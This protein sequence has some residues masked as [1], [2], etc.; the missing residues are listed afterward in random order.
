MGQRR[1]IR[2]V[3]VAM[4]LVAV[5]CGS[6]ETND[7]EEATIEDATETSSV[8]GSA[9]ATTSTTA[10]ATS[11]TAADTSTTSGASTTTQASTTTEAPASSEA[12]GPAIDL[13]GDAVTVN[14]AALASTPS[15]A[16]ATDSADPFFQIHTSGQA[17]GFFLS[18]ELYTEW[19][20]RWSGQTGT[21]DISCSDPETSTGICPYFDPDGPG[22]DP[23]MG[24]DF[25]TQGSITINRLDDS[26]Y[27]IIVHELIFSDGT[28]FN[29]FTMVG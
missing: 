22:P 10:A 16:P 27:E 18:F 25:Q 5:G 21:F 13:Q 24:G 8:I 17:D 3:V 1:G 14:W 23:V 26:G 4:A 6:G 12:T 9:Q 2:L 29:E 28:S 7:G 11:S 15:F 19:G 20:Q